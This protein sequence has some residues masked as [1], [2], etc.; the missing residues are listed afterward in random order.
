MMDLIVY[1]V[2]FFLIILW[3]KY[4]WNRD[5]SRFKK[6]D[7][8]LPGPPAYPLIGSGLLFLGEPRS[9]ENKRNG[10]QEKIIFVILL[11]NTLL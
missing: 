9:T 8:E 4:K 2:I 3:F 5:H 7:A 11:L 6:L 10:A 1:A